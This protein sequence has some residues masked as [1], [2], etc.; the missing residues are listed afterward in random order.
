ML[1]RSILFKE[2]KVFEEEEFILESRPISSKIVD[3][4][5]PQSRD[6]L[7]RISQYLPEYTLHDIEHSHRVLENIENIL[8]TNIKLNIV[9]IKILIY[10]V[11]L[12]DIGMTSDKVEENLF[13]DYANGTDVDKKKN[14]LKKY[15]KTMNKNGSLND[16]YNKEYTKLLKNELKEYTNLLHEKNHT[17]VYSEYIRKNHVKRSKMKLYLLKQFL[18][19]EY[20]SVCLLNHIYTVILAHGL[21]F[22]KLTNEAKYPI[23]ELIS[24][25]KVN[26]LFLST[27]LRLGDLLDADISRTPKY[28]YSFFSFEDKVSISKWEKNL[29][30]IGKEITNYRV[31]FNYFSTSPEQERDIRKYI[32]FVQKQILNTNSLLKY[33]SKK[34]NLSPIINLTIKNDGSYISANKEITIEYDKVKK[35]LM[36]AELYKDSTMFLR[37]LIQNSR[38]ACMMREYYSK[39]LGIDNYKPKITIYFNKRKREL[40]IIDNGIGMNDSSINNYF[41]K[42]GNSSYSD[43]EFYKKYNFYPIGNFGIGIFSAFMVSDEINVNSVK[44]DKD[45]FFDKPINI[46]LKI[47]EKYVIDYITNKSIHEGTHI[48]L[49]MNKKYIKEHNLNNKVMEQSI[50][51]TISRFF[52]VEIFYNNG[53]T[54]I[55]PINEEN[56]LAK[57]KNIINIDEEDYKLELQFSDK[58]RNSYIYNPNNFVQL[59]YNGIQIKYIEKHSGKELSNIFNILRGTI[60]IK[61][62][63]KISLKAS[64]DDIVVNKQS[65]KLFNKINA[66]LFKNILQNNKLNY[67][68]KFARFHNI[69]DVKLEKLFFKNI[70]FKTLINDKYEFISMYE[71]IKNYRY[72]YL[73]DNMY[74]KNNIYK[75]IEME[76][77]SIILIDNYRYVGSIFQILRFYITG[78][79]VVSNNNYSYSVFKTSKTSRNKENYY[80]WYKYTFMDFKDKNVLFISN[81]NSHFGLNIN[82]NHTYGKKLYKKVKKATFY[83]NIFFELTSHN[84]VIHDKTLKKKYH[85]KIALSFI[86]NIYDKFYSKEH[87][88]YMNKKLKLLSKE[89]GIKEYQI[90]K[91]DLLIS[92]LNSK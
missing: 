26:I 67:L 34:L 43:K 45:G 19:F 11:Y 64:R 42:I 63:A 52:D 72:L 69:N 17:N 16:K 21:S 90:T 32:E 4:L 49:S 84:H 77:E 22:D 92:S 36:G 12:H 50:K 55:N 41:I 37:E 62:N 57:E 71:V 27:L 74:I 48:L 1:E 79:N 68:R 60:E 13:R 29:S 31:G 9:E 76:R 65:K 46:K 78:Y 14:I 23:E 39:S 86:N 38:D 33:S 25:D 88:K 89:L 91:A 81:T 6:I 24:N 53:K 59:S 75:K 35:M 66:D 47:D 20:K 15:I 85:K 51:N 70:K 18:D 28:L 58:S 80:D 3:E 61:G 30:L 73:L 83:S 56:L 5:L 44:F 82:K 87:I 40:S 7:N 10:A 2:L 8:P 54:P